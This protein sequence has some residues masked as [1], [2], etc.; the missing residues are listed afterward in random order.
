[1]R[2]SATRM[3]VGERKEDGK[4]EKKRKKGAT[5]SGLLQL[6][7]QRHRSPKT[8]P[9]G[10]DLR[11]QRLCVAVAACC[12]CCWLWNSANGTHRKLNN[13]GQKKRKGGKRKETET[14]VTSGRWWSREAPGEGK[15]GA[16]EEERRSSWPTAFLNLFVLI[17]AFVFLHE[18]PPLMH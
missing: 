17:T 4:G 7:C 10:K 15:S 1:M 14:D 16:E 8:S 11:A 6:P 2:E 9:K 5:P 12:C 13:G 18:A 3:K